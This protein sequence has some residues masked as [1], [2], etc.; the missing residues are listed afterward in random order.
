MWNLFKCERTA[1][2]GN[3]LNRD[4]KALTCVALHAFE[5]LHIQ[6]RRGGFNA[7]EPHGAAAFGASQ[8][9]N[10]GATV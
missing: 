8:D 1:V 6:A 7:G 5:C 3:E 9:S 2:A 4:G 10:F